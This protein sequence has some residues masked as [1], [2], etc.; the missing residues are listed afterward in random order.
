MRDIRIDTLRGLACIFLV[1]Y[2]VIGNNPSNG[3]HIES[4]FLREINDLLETVRMPLFT[5]LSG[6]VY[7]YRPLSGNW[8]KFLK[9]KARRLLIPMLVVGTLFA[10]VQ[11]LVPGTNNKIDNWWLLHIYPVQHFWFVE[12]LFWV[13]VLIIPLELNRLLNNKLV[14]VL[15]IAAFLVLAVGQPYTKLLAF[16]GFIYLT[17]FFLFGMGI[18]R[19]KISPL[20]ILPSLLGFVGIMA[21]IYFLTDGVY[22]RSLMGCV[23]GMF[24]CYFLLGLKLRVTLLARI[25][26]YSYSI[27]IF[28]VFFTAA[29]RIIADKLFSVPDE[30][31]FVIGLLFGIMGPI[32][33]YLVAKQFPLGQLLFLG[34]SQKK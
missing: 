31:N 8:P 33:V 12:A 5:F 6:M 24:S 17:P 29:T 26:I 27:Y 14:T 13:F 1:G 32:A 23:I 18:V 28:H 34:E 19:F 16:K 25:G 30:I 4:G 10:I 20:P 3:L 21:A 2:H 15:I 11:A 9:G 22:G 7:A